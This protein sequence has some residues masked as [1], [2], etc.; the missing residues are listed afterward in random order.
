LIDEHLLRTTRSVVIPKPAI[1][2]R[3]VLI[4]GSTAFSSGAPS[5]EATIASLLEQALRPRVP[6]VEVLTLANPAW[7]STHERIVVENLL[8]E[9]EPDLVIALSGANDVHWGVRGH[10]PLVYRSYFEQ[11]LFDIVAAAH[12]LAGREPPVDPTRSSDEPVPCERIAEAFAMNVQ[13]AARALELRG[14]SYLVA[15]QPTLLTSAKPLTAREKEVRS[16]F[17]ASH[18][19]Y[20]Q[21]CMQ[22]IHD[23]T[24]AASIPGV[25]LVDL[26]G[27]FDADPREIFIDSYHF[28]DRGNAALAAA[29]AEP[30]RLLT[31]GAR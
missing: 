16:A 11:T 15:I 31:L 20:F 24:R 7:S 27:L 22:G 30:A 10:D 18:R 3:I 2:R 23:A 28:G 1:V 29:L 21:T 25:T 4:G 13:L 12:V 9:L 5:E 26:R 19:S 8:G 6:G 14:T 17:P